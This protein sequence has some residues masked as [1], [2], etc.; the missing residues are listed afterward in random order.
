MLRRLQIK[1]A[2]WLLRR[3]F[4]TK[5]QAQKSAS[6]NTVMDYTD[7]C[8]LE[9]GAVNESAIDV[10]EKLAALQAAVE[11]SMERLERLETCR[12]ENPEEGSNEGGSGEP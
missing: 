5:S 7:P 6:Q 12:M 11:L 2:L 1:L 8:H 3:N 10:P 9:L 4:P